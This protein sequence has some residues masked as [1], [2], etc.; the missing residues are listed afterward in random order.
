MCQEILY[1]EEAK[2]VRRGLDGALIP[3]HYDE[4]IYL[5]EHDNIRSFYK[6]VKDYVHKKAQ[7]IAAIR[8]K[9]GLAPCMEAPDTT[10]YDPAS[11]DRIR[12]E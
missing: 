1:L 2:V 4:D 10:E 12:R 7:N 8:G 9:V 3:D 5:D 6:A 11:I